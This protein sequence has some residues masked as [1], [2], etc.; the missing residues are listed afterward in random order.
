MTEEE[1]MQ[2]GY[3]LDLFM[4]DTRKIMSVLLALLRPACAVFELKNRSN[5]LTIARYNDSDNLAQIDVCL[6]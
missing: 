3:K 6:T 2:P 5:D 4:L 1:L